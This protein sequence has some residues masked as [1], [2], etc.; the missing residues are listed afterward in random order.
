MLTVNDKTNMLPDAFYKHYNSNNNKLLTLDND[1]RIEFHNNAINVFDTLDIYKAKHTTLDLYGDLVGEKRK[2]LTDEQYLIAILIKIARNAA[3]TDYT[4]ILKILSKI[5][6]C[7]YT[8]ISIQNDKA[9]AT[10][11]INKIPFVVLLDVNFSIN[12]ALNLLRSLLPI[13]VDIS[14]ANFE[15]TFEFASDNEQDDNNKGFGNISQ[16]IGGFWGTF[17]DDATKII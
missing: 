14:S 4:A 12:Q 1:I 16:S 15:G 7:S 10:I 3:S 2:G 11:K 5:L 9:P 6:K 8:E 17:I 13:T